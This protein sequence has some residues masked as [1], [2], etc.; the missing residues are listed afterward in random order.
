MKNKDHEF[1]RGKKFQ[2]QDDSKESEFSYCKKW[3]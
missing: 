3:K 1:H 2:L